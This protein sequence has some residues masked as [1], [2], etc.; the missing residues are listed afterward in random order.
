MS[1]LVKL[2]E[3]NSARPPVHVTLPASNIDFVAVDQT[4]LVN[5]SNVEPNKPLN[6]SATSHGANLQFT[7]ASIVYQVAIVDNQQVY[8]GTTILSLTGT[9]L[10]DLDVVLDKLPPTQINGGGG[11]PAGA[12]ATQVRTAVAQDRF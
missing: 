8:G 2:F 11:L 7:Q 9:T 1:C 4:T 3:P 10:G 6:N 5:C 12:N